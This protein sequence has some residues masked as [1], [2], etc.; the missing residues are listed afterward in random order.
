VGFCDLLIRASL[1]QVD[2]ALLPPFHHSASMLQRPG[3]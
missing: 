2:A 3:P 1:D